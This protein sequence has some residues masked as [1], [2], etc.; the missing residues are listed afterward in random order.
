MFYFIGLLIIIL[1]VCAN[2]NF[3]KR[4]SGLNGYTVSSEKI[5]VIAMFL[6][7]FLILAMQS[8][9]GN[10]DLRGYSSTFDRYKVY[11]I[12]TFV[13]NFRHIKDPV[14]HLCALFV[15]K[16]GADFH[17]WYL[18]ISFLYT[19]SIYLLV[20]RYS[21]NVYISYIVLIS[22]GGFGFAFSGLRQTL[23]L[24][25]LMF[26]FRFLEGKKFL[27]F[28]L[29]VI[30]AS[31]FHSTAFIFIFAY[32]LYRL[33]LHFR[34]LFFIFIGMMI[35]ILNARPLMRIY[36]ELIGTEEFYSAYLE[37]ESSLSISGVV[38]FTSIAVFC[39][40]SFMIG[41]TDA[42]YE[43]LCNLALFSITFRILAVSVFAEFFRVSMYFSVFDIIMIAEAC[44]CGKNN[45]SFA[46][47]KTF[48]ATLAL[49]AYYF[50]SP[51]GAIVNFIMR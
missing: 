13:Q 22:V 37:K 42:K 29:F 9:N 33:K 20:S 3:Q 10:G 47:L 18:I 8:E 23:A 15:S 36:M 44:A 24:T 32:P 19:F 28:V 48:G 7:L 43:G 50:V 49:T 31:M 2:I 27:K 26:S 39:I 6:I 30:L 12:T 4:Q 35:I 5:F 17:I 1:F 51:S 14:Y 46:Q 34:D 45:K 11:S 38:I 41:K 40:I 16:L 21:A 25:F